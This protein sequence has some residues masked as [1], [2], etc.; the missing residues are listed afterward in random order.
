MY[1]NRRSLI[2][3]GEISFH[4]VNDDLI[5]GVIIPLDVSGG[6]PLVGRRGRACF[7]AETQSEAS[8]KVLLLR[9]DLVRSRGTGTLSAERE[10]FRTVVS[11]MMRS[12]V[13]KV[14]A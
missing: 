10:C 12:W 3:S 4:G 14:P 11:A 5:G 7:G 2:Q 6:V 13:G 9:W 8:A 1:G